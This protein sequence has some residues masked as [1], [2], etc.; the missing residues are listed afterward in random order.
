MSQQEIRDFIMVVKVDGE[1]VTLPLHQ[2]D[3]VQASLGSNPLAVVVMKGQEG[4]QGG[5]LVIQETAE[6]FLHRCQKLHQALHE[7]DLPAINHH[8]APA[9]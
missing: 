8:L 7:R 3:R 1:V 9:W 4:H 5:I 6:C 2:I